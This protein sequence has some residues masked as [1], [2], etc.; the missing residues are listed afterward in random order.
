M[1]AMH[2]AH[3]QDT[4]C[5]RVKIEIKQ[6]LTLERQAFDNNTTDTGVIEDISVVVKVTDENGTPVEVSDDPNNHTAKFFIRLT[7]KDKIE[8]VDGTG[9]VNPQTT[10]TIDWLLIPAPGAAGNNPLGKKFLLGR[11]CNTASAV[12]SRAWMSSLSSRSRY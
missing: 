7:S 10:A 3:A 9:T 8:A 1:F 5:A 2:G 12:M 6:K 11:L 4:V